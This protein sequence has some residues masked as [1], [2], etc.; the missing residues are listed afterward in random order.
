MGDQFGIQG[1]LQSV[2][3]MLAGAAT[4]AMVVCI[5]LVVGGVVT[6]ARGNA[7]SWTN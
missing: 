4:V 5:A 1:A 6:V 3:H 7:E 2:T